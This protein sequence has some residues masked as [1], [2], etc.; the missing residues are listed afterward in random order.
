MDNWC[1]IRTITYEDT[2]GNRTRELRKNFQ[3][4]IKEAIF[5]YESILEFLPAPLHLVLGIGG[6]MEQHFSVYLDKAENLETEMKKFTGYKKDKL[7][8]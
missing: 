8:R 7:K 5:K 6:D 2:H 4:Q 1:K 3:S